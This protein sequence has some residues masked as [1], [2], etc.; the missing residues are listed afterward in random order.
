MK[1]IEVLHVQP[2]LEAVRVT[3]AVFEGRVADD[4]RGGHKGNL[5]D[6]GIETTVVADRRA[7]GAE[8]QRTKDEFQLKST[9][10]YIL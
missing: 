3:F 1:S 9:L 4:N 5:P 6:R 10:L 8:Y 7:N 2:H